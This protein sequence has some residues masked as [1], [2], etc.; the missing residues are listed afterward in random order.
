MLASRP[1]GILDISCRLFCSH[2][3]IHCIPDAVSE[4]T[5][6]NKNN[7]ELLQRS[8]LKNYELI[9]VVKDWT[10]RCGICFKGRAPASFRGQ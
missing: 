6:L 5:K 4:L 8:M 9:D 10:A 7:D 2:E 1:S 3:T